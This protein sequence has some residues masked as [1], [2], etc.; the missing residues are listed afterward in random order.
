MFLNFDASSKFLVSVPLKADDLVEPVSL[1]CPNILCLVIS[2]SLVSSQKY[3]YER[4]ISFTLD[5]VPNDQ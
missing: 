3:N 5:M 4:G 1:A 2:K